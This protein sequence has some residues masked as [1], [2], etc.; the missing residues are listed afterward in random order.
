MN[1]LGVHPC[2]VTVLSL[3]ALTLV[4]LSAAAQPPSENSLAAKLQ[5]F[6][7]RHAIAGAVMVVA[8]Q[9]KVLAC[10]A[11]GYADLQAGKAMS[12]DDLFE[13]A[14]MSK[15]ITATAVMM[16]VDDGKLSVDDPVAKYLPEFGLQMVV[17]EKDEQHMVLKRPEHPL[18]IRH[19]LTHTG[20]LLYSGPIETPTL[21][22]L[23]LRTV[24][25]EHALLPLQFEPGTKYLYSSAGMSTLARIVEVVSGMP[26]EKFLEDRLFHPLGMKDTTFWPAGQQL[27]RLVKCYKLNAGKTDLEESQLDARFSFPLNDTVHRHPMAGI[28]LFSTAGD[29]L[30]FC[31]MYLGGGVCDGKRYLSEATVARMTSRQVPVDIKSDYGFG[32]ATGKDGQFSHGGSFNTFMAV[33]PGTGLITI[34]LTQHTG[35]LPKGGEAARHTFEAAARELAPATAITPAVRVIPGEY[36]AFYLVDGRVFGIGSNRAG[37]AGMGNIDPG[38]VVPPAPVKLPADR[39][40]VDVAAGGYSALAL[41]ADGRVWTWGGNTFGQRGSGALGGASAAADPSDGVPFLVPT[42]NTGATFDGVTQVASGF[43][44]D[45]ALKKDGSVWVWGQSGKHVG[46]SS[47][48]IG[49]GVTDTVSVMR[50]TRVPFPPGT[51]IAKLAAASE[52]LFA[53]DARGGVWSWGGGPDS[54]ENRGSGEADFATPHPLPGLPPIRELAVSDTFGYAL[55]I[56]GALWGW[57][58]RGTYLGLGPAK[59]GWVPVATPVKLSFPEFGGRNIVAVSASA[60]ASHVILD[61]GSLWGWGDAAMGEVGDGT[62]L[63]LSRHGFAW[64]WG[65]FECMVFRPVRIAPE[66]SDFCTLYSSSQ[67][68]YTYAATRDGKLYSW[69]RNKTGVLGNGVLPTGDAA[70]HPN[71]WDVAKATLVSPMTLKTATPVPSRP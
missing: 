55:D 5:P 45:A 33:D 60:H 51:V 65:T 6:V 14:S 53:I 54:K 61:D 57:G 63:D 36:Q 15:P 24:A 43:V 48:V 19:L 17:A 9:D 66:V 30:K 37:E 39:K 32:W 64:D 8:T 42:D 49:S 52:T 69:G 18:L 25:E 3:A 13:I 71:S 34:Y 58:I 22:G 16:L 11:V 29:I 26:F 7:D 40:F 56:T 2:G 38:D 67:A 23:P 70:T 20:G 31:R 10:E 41:D 1:H 47:G 12:T 27:S 44:F 62:Q 35:E 50:P 28:G 68:F 21:D 4:A 46:N 59:G